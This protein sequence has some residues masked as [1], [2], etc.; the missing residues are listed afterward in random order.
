MNVMDYAWLKQD[1]YVDFDNVPPAS[2]VDLVNGLC[3]TVYDGP[4]WTGNAVDLIAQKHAGWKWIANT[5]DNQPRMGDIIV[6]HANI[7]TLTIGPFGH[8][9]ICLVSNK[10]QFVSMDQDWPMASPVRMVAHSFLGVA[11]WQRKVS[12]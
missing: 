8:T 4:R 6:W 5:P 2:C 9:S 11:G 10:M 1:R 7:P 3:A 12:L